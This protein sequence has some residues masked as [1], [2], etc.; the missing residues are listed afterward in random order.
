MFINGFILNIFKE[1]LLRMTGNG[2]PKREYLENVRIMMEAG[3]YD[4]VGD[5]EYIVA[6]SSRKSRIGTNSYRRR[7]YYVQV[8]L[9]K[10]QIIQSVT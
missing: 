1:K 5:Q 4:V 8:L 9:V 6:A 10:V 2:G 7:R 3:K